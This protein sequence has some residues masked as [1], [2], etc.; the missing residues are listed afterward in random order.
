MLRCVAAVSCAFLASVLVSVV[1]A[2]DCPG[3]PDAL[4]TSRTL[5]IDPTEHRL[6]G[7][8]QYAETLP[9][10]PKEVVITFDDGPLPPNTDAILRVLAAECV[11]V[12]YFLVGTMARAYPD[13]VRK[14]FNAGHTLGTHSQSH[15]LTFDRMPLERAQQE[16]EGGIASVGAALGDPHAVAPFFRIPGLMR[17]DRVEAYLGSHSLV[18]W[19]SDVVAD[20][21]FH[22]LGPAEVAKRAVARL[23]TA[24]RGILLL[25]DIHARTVAA[26]PMI[27]HEL[28][29]RGF[30]VVH[31]VAAT[32]DL[33]KTPT[34]PKLWATHKAEKLHW[35]QTADLGPAVL[36]VSALANS[37]IFRPSDA[38]AVSAMGAVSDDLQGTIVRLSSRRVWPRGQ[39]AALPV[40]AGELPDL[41]PSLESPDSPAYMLTPKRFSHLAPRSAA[42]RHDRI[43]RRPA[44]H[45]AKPSSARVAAANAV[46]PIP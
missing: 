32:P 45:I 8:M 38:K 37:P 46:L 24:G 11:K 21:W 26:V 15:P 9:L 25:H 6:L 35:P 18:T 19:S 29:A 34:D 1:H 23:E 14:I 43:L 28:K 3:N 4:G 36:P 16:I 27:L 17:A 13:T 41:S 5:V 20:D 40:R 33:P 42:A 44:R 10:G 2:A 22:R 12:T 39:G 7:S 31:V 30:H